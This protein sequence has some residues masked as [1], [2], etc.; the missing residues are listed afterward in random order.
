MEQP[1]KGVCVG[2]RR[3]LIA[4]H[5][6]DF[7]G[8]NHEADDGRVYAAGRIDDQYIQVFANLTEGVNEPR[9]LD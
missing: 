3:G 8:S 2:D 6:Q 5:D 9:K 7:P 4:H 1:D